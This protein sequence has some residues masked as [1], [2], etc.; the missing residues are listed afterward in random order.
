VPVS[1]TSVTMYLSTFLSFYETS[2]KNFNL[3]RQ[4]QQVWKPLGP[5][6]ENWASFRKHE[7]LQSKMCGSC[8]NNAVKA[9]GGG[10]CELKYFSCKA[11]PTKIELNNSQHKIK[12]EYLLSRVERVCLNR[13]RP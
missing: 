9:L 10:S 11:F 4:E 13:M 2:M 1:L 12:S 6:E 3:L 7:C 5:R 8:N